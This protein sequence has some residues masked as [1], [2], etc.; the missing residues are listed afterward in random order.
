[1]RWTRVGRVFLFETPVAMRSP[2]GR[3]FDY[4]MEPQVG[5]AGGKQ[6][7]Y[8]VLTPELQLPGTT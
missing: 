1:M 5:T 2:I 6:A 8:Q 7:G 3:P 4:S